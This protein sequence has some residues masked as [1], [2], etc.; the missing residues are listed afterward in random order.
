MTTR[1][2]AVI[3]AAVVLTLAADAALAG[4]A[5]L[6]ESPD[7]YTLSNGTLSATVDKRS[8]N[9]SSL[10]YHDT[11]ILN[12]NPRHPAGFWSHSA[13][14]DQTTATITIDPKSNERQ[15]AE[16]S[17]KG[18][19]NG[20]PMGAG[21]GGSTICDVEIRWSL[22]ADDSAHRHAVELRGQVQQPRALGRDHTTRGGKPAHGAEQSRV[23][24]QLRRVD[25]R[26]AAADHD[27]R[28][29]LGQRLVS[30]RIE[31]HDL[32]ARGREQLGVLGVAERER[33]ASGHG[34]H[35]T[36]AA[37]HRTA[38]LTDRELR[39]PR[40]LRRH[41]RRARRDP[42]DP[43]HV[44]VLLD[45]VDQRVHGGQRV[46]GGSGRNPYGCGTAGAE[47]RS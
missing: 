27:G 34:H 23:I 20:R 36:R 42:L 6:I 25:L 43:V 47:Q 4:P 19:S 3:A 44:E 24:S 8:G 9:L 39:R 1:R 35:R 10:R 38:E 22:G 21:P 16:V 28:R 2:A 14:S 33:R 12:P 5:T 29:A 32:G 18:L 46:R 40:L 41:L 31:R 13:S 7:T 11:E 17:V 26:E 37:A 45:Q 15:R 30:Q